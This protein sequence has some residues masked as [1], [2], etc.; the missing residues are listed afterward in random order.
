MSIRAIRVVTTVP[1]FAGAALAWWI[2]Y[3]VV[4][5]LVAIAGVLLAALQWMTVRALQ[6]NVPPEPPPPDGSLADQKRGPV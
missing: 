4:A 2:D 6:H 1:L 5:L 3:Q